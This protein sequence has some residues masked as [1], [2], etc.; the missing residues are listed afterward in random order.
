[1]LL[2]CAKRLAPGVQ[3]G[4]QQY[5]RE[6][7]MTEDEAEVRAIE[8]LANAGHIFKCDMMDKGVE[9]G[10]FGREQAAID[11][12]TR[13]S[14]YRYPTKRRKQSGEGYRFSDETLM[15]TALA[16]A[17]LRRQNTCVLSNDTDCVTIMKQLT[18]NL[19]WVMTTA[20]FKAKGMNP[21][22]DKFIDRWKGWCQHGN[23]GRGPAPADE[24]CRSRAP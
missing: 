17:L 8:G 9:R 12:G 23:R 16:N 10:L 6:M 19:L 4:K 13:R 2:E 20:E 21:G 11:K 24:P 7:G 3:M 22:I 14:W 15:A 5:M 1:M 18:D